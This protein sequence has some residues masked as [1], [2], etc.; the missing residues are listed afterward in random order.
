MALKSKTDRSKLLVR[1]A[2]YFERVRKGCYVGYRKIDEGDGTWLGRWRDE[3]GKQHYYPL[4]HVDSYDAAVK[5]LLTW[6]DQNERGIAPKALTVGDICKQ[7]ENHLRTHKSVESAH[8]ADGRFKRLVYDKHIDSIP[9]DKLKATDVAKWTNAQ[10]DSVDDEDDDEMRS[11][12]ASANRNLT[13]LKAALN[14]AYRNRLVGSDSGWKPVSRF[15]NTS[16]RRQYY[17]SLDER[18]RLL[19]ELP[20]DLRQLVEALLL[21]AARPGELAA[22][23]VRDF[24]KKQGTLMIPDG[25]T[26]RRIVTLSSEAAKR[27]ENVAKN[28]IGNTWLFTRCDGQQWTKDRWKKI[29]KRTVEKVGLPDDVV[30]YS[31]R[32]TAISEMI[33]GGMDSFIVARLSGTSTTMID[34]HYGHLKHDTTRNKLNLINLL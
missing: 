10:L 4:E 28:K 32:H 7:Y 29:F 8:D 24:D 6:F 12:K 5:A 27:F 11:A 17:L 22:V 13:C 26:G 20:A 25:K 15:P 9:L 2:P 21:T 14:F 31:I 34:K 33:S 1:P 23:A 16:N 3:T 19:N 18:R 30:I